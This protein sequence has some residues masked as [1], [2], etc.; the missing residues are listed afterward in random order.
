MTLPSNFQFSQGSLQDYDNCPRRFQ[1]RYIEH[2]SWPALQVEPALENE[3]NM[4]LGASFHRMVHRYLLGVPEKDITDS[5]KTNQH[6]NRWWNNFVS[7]NS[8]K[9]LLDSISITRHPEITL[10]AP[11]G[12]YRLVAKYDLILIEP[13][14][15]AIIFDWKSSSHQPKYARMAIKYQ[16][17]VYPFVLSKAGNFLNNEKPLAPEQITMIY[18]YANFPKEPFR[19]S[20]N[21]SGIAN[22]HAKLL[23]IIDEIQS[24]SDKIAPL[25]ENEKLCQYCVYRSLCKR[26]VKAGTLD[27]FEDMEESKSNDIDIDFDQIAEI[28]Y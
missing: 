26:G 21:A 18:W 10:S 22:H 3:H 15:R 25:T 11:I 12:N 16:T 2:L 27:K 24:L 8:I 14:Q 1:L 13:G 20:Q 9:K 17:I 6:L 23:A 19:Y 7:D 28:F 5:I 4:H